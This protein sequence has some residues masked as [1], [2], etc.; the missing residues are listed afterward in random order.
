MPL[1]LHGIATSVCGFDEA[2]APRPIRLRE[3]FDNIGPDELFIARN[4]V[5]ARK[6]REAGVP[7]IV[8]IG[9]SPAE[10]EDEASR[11]VVMPPQFGYLA[12][13]DIIGIHPA[14]KRFRSLYR[15]SS[16]HNSFLVT[17]RCN[18]Y[19]LM[20]SQPPRNVDDSWILDEIRAAIPLIDSQCRIT[21]IYG[22]RTSTRLERVH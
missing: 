9:A 11:L 18:N 1:A 12:D 16:L 4:A 10:I 2:E 5:D 13:G 7:G 20:C 15:R 17:E 19:C 8:V 3:A 6:A 21:G 22:R 14:T